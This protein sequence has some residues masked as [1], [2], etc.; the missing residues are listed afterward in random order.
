MCIEA[1]DKKEIA[2]AVNQADLIS[3]DGMPL[4]KALQYLKGVKTSRAAGM[5]LLPELL[6]QAEKNDFSV[7]FFG[8]TNEMLELTSDYI[9]KK[10]PLLQKVN[11]YSPPFR[12]LELNEQTEI[13]NRINST[14]P[15]LVFVVLGCPKQE[16]WM[17][18]HKNKIQACMLGI[19]GALPVIV[20][21]QRRA[22]L[23][24]QKTSL[25]WLY[26]LLQEPQRLLKRYMYTN[27]KFI[28]LFL[29]AL[30]CSK[31]RINECYYSKS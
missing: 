18:D 2:S 9:K 11:F 31:L 4:V 28:L 21:M 19:G 17:F 25:E 29:W 24:M 7:F 1:W 16:K 14:A 20:G 15:N 6:A 5:D 8:G 3:P 22:P 23:W 27:S 30:I 10:Y 12:Q 13:I 26:R